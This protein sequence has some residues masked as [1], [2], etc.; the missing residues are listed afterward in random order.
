M[1]GWLAYLLHDNFAAFFSLILSGHSVIGRTPITELHIARNYTFCYFRRSN[2]C[3]L[4]NERLNDF[5][6]FLRYLGT[7]SSIVYRRQ[8]VLPITAMKQTTRNNTI[9]KEYIAT[10]IDKI[11]LV[12]SSP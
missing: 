2:E 6:P 9:C 7:V 5:A 3:R 12:M 1:V 4:G 10:S 11:R 8:Y